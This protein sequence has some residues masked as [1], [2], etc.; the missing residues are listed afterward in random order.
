MFD[1]FPSYLGIKPHGSY[2][3]DQATPMTTS[4]VEVGC[5]TTST[6]NFCAAK[7]LA[8]GKMNY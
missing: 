7:V 5:K 1:V 4:A 2:D 8:E 3:C 6:G